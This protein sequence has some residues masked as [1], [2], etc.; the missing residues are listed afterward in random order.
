MRG[1]CDWR[2]M[3]TCSCVSNSPSMVNI[4]RC[5]FPGQNK[6]ASSLLIFNYWGPGPIK[7]VAGCEA[8][9]SQKRI[10]SLDSTLMLPHTNTAHIGAGTLSA[11]DGLR[12]IPP[13][14]RAKAVLHAHHCFPEKGIKLK[15]AEGISVLFSGLV[16]Q[17][18][19]K[20]KNDGVTKP[21]AQNGFWWSYVM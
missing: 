5:C 15:K 17:K 19:R 6:I 10:L 13:S 11:R 4:R 8:M 18:S 3:A 12:D 16:N 9:Q 2:L 14:L 7:R 1:G 21:A 20:C